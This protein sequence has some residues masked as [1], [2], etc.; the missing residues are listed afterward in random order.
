MHW[1]GTATHQ[2]CPNCATG[3]SKLWAKLWVRYAFGLST[4]VY[5]VG[6]CTAACENMLDVDYDD[7]NDS[8]LI[9]E[10]A[11]GWVGVPTASESE[12]AFEKI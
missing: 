5:I 4:T 9:A 6:Y 2:Y 3:Q 7:D 10:M 1:L 11:D 8:E 12:P